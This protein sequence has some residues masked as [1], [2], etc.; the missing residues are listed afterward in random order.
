MLN[1]DHKHKFGKWYRCKDVLPKLGESV[2]TRVGTTG[3]MML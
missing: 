3:Y 1:L 2:L